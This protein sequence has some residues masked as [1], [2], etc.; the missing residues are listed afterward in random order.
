MTREKFQRGVQRAT[1]MGAWFCERA[2]KRTGEGNTYDQWYV[3]QVK[4]QFALSLEGAIKV[5]TIGGKVSLELTFKR[6]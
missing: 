5:V 4:P 1:G 3:D 6:S 2:K